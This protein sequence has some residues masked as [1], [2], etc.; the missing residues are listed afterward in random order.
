MLLQMIKEMSYESR[1]WI[2][3]AQDRVPWLV[4]VLAILNLLLDRLCRLVVR[5][6][7]CQTG[8]PVFDSRRYQIF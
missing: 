2:T 4:V 5:V 8:G 7:G 1:S 6:P 3:L